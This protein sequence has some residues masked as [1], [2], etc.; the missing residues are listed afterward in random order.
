[1]VADVLP[2]YQQA[3]S[4]GDWLQLVAPYV[5][6]A[7]YPSLSRVNRRFWSVFAPRTWRDPRATSRHLGWDRDGDALSW[8]LSFFHQKLG[9][10]A[11][12]TRVLIRVLDARDAAG[13]YQFGSYLGLSESAFEQALDLLPN[14]ESLLIDNH[15][16]LDLGF[17]R[18]VS[19]RTPGGRLRMLSLANCPNG[20]AAALAS[21]FFLRGLV[22]LDVSG[23]SAVAPEALAVRCLPALR[24]LKL[25]RKGIDTA[26]F[27]AL[28]SI[29]RH[30]LWSLDVSDNRMTDDALATFVCF[31]VPPTVLRSD[32]HAQLEGTL[33]K[34][35]LVTASYGPFYILRD[36]IRSVPFLPRERYLVDAPPYNPRSDAGTGVVRRL[37]RSDGS[38][39]VR[40]DTA[41]G[42]LRLLARDNPAAATDH[43]PGSRGITH[44]H[45]SGNRFSTTA[46]ERMLRL[47]NGQLEHFDCAS[48]RLYPPPFCAQSVKMSKA[49]AMHGFLGMPH[50]FRSVWAPNLRSLRIHHSLV[51]NIPT[52]EIQN[53]HA[54]EC[55]YVA[56]AQMLPRLDRAY[57]PYFSPDTNPRLESLTLTCIP[58]HSLGPLLRNLACFLRNL[59]RQERFLANMNK[60]EA[61]RPGRP[62]RLLR[63]LRYLNLE[64]E[65][66]ALSPL[67]LDAQELLA[68]GEKLYSFFGG[69]DDRQPAPSPPLV[70][71]LW[72][73]HDKASTALGPETVPSRTAYNPAQMLESERDYGKEQWVTYKEGDLPEMVVWAGNPNSR[74]PVV[75]AYH[76]L[77]VEHRWREGAGPASLSQVLAG[78]PTE[79][80]IFHSVWFMASLPQAL[81]IPPLPTIRSSPWVVDVASELRRHRVPT[82]EA[83][84]RALK[85]D[86]NTLHWHWNGILQFVDTTPKFEG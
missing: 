6:V 62:L 53:H 10:L 59:G 21:A 40:L 25:R 7:D 60:A 35:P 37:S 77:V 70:E 69:P 57:P 28:A 47:S 73:C 86:P 3:V 32:D 55:I 13:S 24:I 50:I 1:M 76:K 63:G 34:T 15:T 22:Y 19:E 82:F 52:L 74:N 75:R 68:N 72:D 64:I 11:T 54:I 71:L 14:A 8:W 39:P 58:R 79:C 81:Q 2:S 20:A 84:M 49:V 30:R 61:A 33:K 4:R 29:I 48:A 85:C 46:L 23:A 31:L 27:N 67:E 5:A 43:L 36:P 12:R 80:I 51:T 56:E 44:L 9:T 42:V 41:N 16:D 83:S 26:Q 38:A 45:L 66:I 65:P 18:R 17:L 78:A